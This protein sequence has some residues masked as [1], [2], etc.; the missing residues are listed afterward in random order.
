MPPI[1]CN[2]FFRGEIPVLQKKKSL[3]NLTDIKK[4]ESNSGVFGSLIDAL[5]INPWDTG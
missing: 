4:I 2:T 5:Y 3:R 1:T